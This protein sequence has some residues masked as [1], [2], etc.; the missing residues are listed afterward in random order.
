MAALTVLVV[1]QACTTASLEDASPVAAFPPPPVAAPV[2]K[3]ATNEPPVRAQ[4]LQA[5]RGA[6]DTGAFPNLNITP[7]K[8]AEQISN[9]DKAASIAQL[10]AVQQRQAAGGPSVTAADEEAELRALGESHARDAL[11]TIEKSQ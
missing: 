5:E 10:K 11:K 4:A 8:A 1:L 9:E 2:A 3:A 6:K 7:G